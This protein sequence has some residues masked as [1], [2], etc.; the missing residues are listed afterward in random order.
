MQMADACVVVG[1]RT[2][3]AQRH[4]MVDG[5]VSAVRVDGR[6]INGFV[7][8]TADPVV[9][10]RQDENVNELVLNFVH[11][12][13]TGVRIAEGLLWVTLAPITDASC[14]RFRVGGGVAARRFTSAFGELRI[15]LS[16]LG[17]PDPCLFIYP[18]RIGL[19]VG[20]DSVLVKFV[21]FAL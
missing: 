8:D 6:R 19:G 17:G 3:K 20:D 18:N 12:S 14:D 2:A 13:A 7:A 4:H 21:V 1:V 9:T 11:P 15:V 16:A 10:F 5:P